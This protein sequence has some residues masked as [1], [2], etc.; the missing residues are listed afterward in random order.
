MSTYNV[1]LK[2]VVDDSYEIEIGF[3]LQDKLI[4]E[5]KNGLVGNIKKFVVVTDSIVKD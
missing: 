1:Q 4:S 5:I 2:R 3:G